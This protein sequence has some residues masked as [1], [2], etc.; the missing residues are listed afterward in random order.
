MAIIKR[1]IK[2]VQQAYLPKLKYALWKVCWK[3]LF[4]HCIL[5]FYSGVCVPPYN[6]HYVFVYK[7]FTVMMFVFSLCYKRFT[8][9]NA[10]T[11]CKRNLIYTINYAIIQTYSYFTL[12]K[13]SIAITSALILLVNVWQYVSYVHSLIY[14]QKSKTYEGMS[15]HFAQFHAFLF[16]PTYDLPSLIP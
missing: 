2:F 13:L 4:P 8:N 16:I 15:L 14:S 12:M 7:L 10:T 11:C 6:V 5:I 1:K 3:V 9:Y